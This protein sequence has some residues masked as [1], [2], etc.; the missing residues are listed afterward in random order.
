MKADRPLPLPDKLSAAFWEAAREHRLE[1]QRCSD[2]RR[3]NHVPTLLCPSCGSSDLAFEP[4]SGRASLYSWT[5]IHDPPAPGFADMLP[6][7]VGLVELE[8]Q[9]RLLLAS[10][11]VGIGPDALR[12]SLQL[13]VTFEDIDG[14]VALPQFRPAQR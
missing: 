8:E 1:I 12:L 13:E 4:V 10:N 3:W 2:C 14:D 7:I 9:E 5:V 11:I 6:L